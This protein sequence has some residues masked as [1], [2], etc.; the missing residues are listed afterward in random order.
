MENDPVKQFRKEVYKDIPAPEYDKIKE[1]EMYIPM[2]DGVRLHSRVFMPQGKRSKWPVILIRNLY[3]SHELTMPEA[4]R[5]FAE[6]G[7]VAVYSSVRGALKS[8]GEFIPI[9]NERAD[10]RATIDWIAKQDWCDGNIACFGASYLSHVQWCL[11]DYHHPALKT[12]FISFSGSHQYSAYYRRGMFRY[13]LATGW[14]AQMLAGGAK[15]NLDPMELFGAL[16]KAYEVKPQIGLGKEL[17]GKDCEWYNAWA[18]SIRETDPCWTKGVCGELHDAIKNIKIPLFLTSGWFDVF[19][20]AELDMYRS[21]PEKVRKQSRFVI[22]PWHHGGVPSGA[23]SYPGENILGYLQMK[24]ALEWFDYQLK[25]K[26]Y[27]H[28]TGVIEAY[29][30]RENQWH[31]YKKAFPKAKGKSYYFSSAKSDVRGWSIGERCPKI[32]SKLQYVYDPADPVITAGGNILSNIK[33]LSNPGPECSVFQKEIGSRADVLSF[34]SEKLK[35]DMPLLGKIKAKMYVSSSAPAT[36]FTIKVMEMTEDGKSV[37]IIDDITDIRWK[38]EHIVTNYK[39]NA[40]AELNLETL[41]ID[42]TVK[43]GSRIRIDISSSNYPAYH[44]HPN[45]SE[46]WAI[47]TNSQKAQQTIYFGTDHPSQIIFPVSKK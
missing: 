1:T 42:W 46:N 27:P 29:R 21:L 6:H 23:L 38:D 43:K 13:E 37:N 47:T 8:E 26:K 44:I 28:K 10:G 14:C 30:I 31:I 36:A 24:A 17:S 40:V 5:I 11:A 7:Y 2:K 18:T 35:A 20:R 19:T 34:V 33:D 3:A 16:Y 4:A 15:R 32:A 12:L 41:D 22:G 45:V 39:P 25:G 9:V